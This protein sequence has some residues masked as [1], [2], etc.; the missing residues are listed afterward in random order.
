M[1]IVPVF[2]AGSIPVLFVN[3]SGGCMRDFSTW[4]AAVRMPWCSFP[5]FPAG[6]VGGCRKMPSL[7]GCPGKAD[8]PIGVSRACICRIVG[9]GEFCCCLA[10]CAETV[11]RKLPDSWGP[12]V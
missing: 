11:R 6:F 3:E 4:Q 10:G 8:R 5:D 2:D 1:R 7:R 12:A 9:G